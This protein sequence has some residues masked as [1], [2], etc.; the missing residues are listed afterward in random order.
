MTHSGDKAAT[1]S[2]KAVFA[3]PGG[4]SLYI[5]PL[6]VIISSPPPLGRIP[7]NQWHRLPLLSRLYCCIALLPLRFITPPLHFSTYRILNL[8]Q[9]TLEMIQNALSHTNLNMLYNPRKRTQL[10]FIM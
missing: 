6:G 8:Q 9:Q 2:A 1:G 10:H 7:V 4:R 5:L 3:P